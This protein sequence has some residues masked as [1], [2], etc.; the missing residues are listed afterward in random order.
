MTDTLALPK[1]ARHIHLVGIGGIGVSALAPVL[2]SRG[3]SV[4]GSDPARHGVTD[5]LQQLGIPIVH[6]HKPENITGASLVVV[7]SAVKDTNPEVKAALDKGI[8]VWPR[9]KMLGY[10]LQERKSIVVTGTHGKTTVTAMIACVLADAGLDP[11]AFI[12]GELPSL[13]GNVRVGKGEWMVAEGDESDGSFTYLKPDIAIV[14]NIDA[15]H[16][17]FYS[18]VEA[19]VERFHEFLQGVKEEGWIVL[20][21]DCDRAVALADRVGRR[22]KTYGFSDRAEMQALDYARTGRGWGCEVRMGERSLGKL[23]L[24]VSGKANCHNALAVLRIGEIL[25]LPFERVAESLSHYEGVKRRMEEKGTV[26]G[27]TVVDDYAHHPAEIR[28]TLGAL[29]DRYNG[30]MIGIFQPHLYSR[31]LKLREEFGQAFQGLDLLILTDIYPARETPLPG[32]SGEVLLA[33][34]RRSGVP[35][36]YIP[37]LEEIPIFLREAVK[38]GDVVVTMGAGDVWKVGEQFVEQKF[39]A[40][41]V[42]G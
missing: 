14:N 22:C 1:G 19:I 26:R 31:T 33:P 20:S 29:R 25:G 11:T 39:P 41:E 37:R 35:V 42:N 30:R 32:V 18:D 5:R 17:D 23:H 36:L 2:L 9:A 13:G 16:L 34:V 4:S 40:E 28:A 7:T 6:E 3:F 10:L 8:P 24:R 38:E 21:A 12:G 15:D 27:V